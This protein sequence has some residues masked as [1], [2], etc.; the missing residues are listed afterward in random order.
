VS[1]RRLL[2]NVK[3]PERGTDSGDRCG[4]NISALRW[5]DYPKG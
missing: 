3:P 4:V 1:I 5:N 2:A